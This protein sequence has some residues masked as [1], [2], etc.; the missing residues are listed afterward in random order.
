MRVEEIVRAK[1][2]KTVTIG[3]DALVAEAAEI[4]A[5]H[6]WGLVVVCSE[7]ER[8]VG[9]IS[10]RDIIRAVAE[11]SGDISVLEVSQLL[12]TNPVTCG[13]EDDIRDVFETMSKHHF[14]HM[15]VVQYGKLAGLV[16]VA[17]ILKFLVEESD[18]DKRATIYS[19]LEYI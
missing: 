8:V 7:G 16:S 11:V 5:S 4:M 18:M 15:P 9:V 2:D 1:G 14:R 19:Y 13:L 17:D 10:E 12:T 3:T 6:R